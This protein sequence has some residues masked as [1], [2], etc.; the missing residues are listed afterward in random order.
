LIELFQ[1]ALETPHGG[2]D[3]PAADL[4]MSGVAVRDGG[5]D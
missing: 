5:V 4:G 3:Q 1:C 2:P